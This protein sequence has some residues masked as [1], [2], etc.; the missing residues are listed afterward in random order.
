[1]AV[2][3]I[4]VDDLTNEPGA[5][6]IEF[7]VEKNQ[8]EIDL[9]QA[10]EDNFYK[11]LKPFISKARTVRGKAKA[12]AVKP[13]KTASKSTN[14]AASDADK[15]NYDE[16]RKWAKSKGKHVAGRGRISRDLLDEFDAEQQ[17]AVEA[18][19]VN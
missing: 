8:Y 6:T 15:R 1:M 18:V 11:A 7:G 10:S 3:N 13:K 2:K 5:R 14:G 4:R 9:A 12:A 16:V 19:S 17:E